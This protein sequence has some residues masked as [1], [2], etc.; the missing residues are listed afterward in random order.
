MGVGRTRVSESDLLIRIMNQM[1]LV[2]SFLLFSAI[3][4]YFS[5]P[6]NGLTCTKD[7]DSLCKCHLSD[8]AEGTIDLSNLFSG[9]P[10]KASRYVRKLTGLI[11]Y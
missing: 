3:P 8:G 5:N 4:V 2:S 9:G 1:G 11:T 7:P 6:S 10:V